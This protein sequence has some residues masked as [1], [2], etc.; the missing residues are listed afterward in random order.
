MLRW[1]KKLQVWPYPHVLL[2]IVEMYQIIAMRQG[3]VIFLVVFLLCCLWRV[4]KCQ[5][6]IMLFCECHR[7]VVILVYV[8]VMKI[9]LWGRVQQLEK[10]DGTR[11][12]FFLMWAGRVFRKDSK[13]SFPIVM[14]LVS[15]RHVRA[16]ETELLRNL[17]FGERPCSCLLCNFQHI[18]L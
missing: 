1:D 10:G 9:I 8:V 4:C 6:V 7:N 13:F 15:G 14:F 16:S 17:F 11:N 18:F 12:V 2:K 3:I 5:S